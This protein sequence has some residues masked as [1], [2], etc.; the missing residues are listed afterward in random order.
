MSKR[1]YYDVLGVAKGAD[2]KD[3]KKAYRSL[4]N[5]YHPDKN[6][7]NEEALDKFKE[8]AEAYEILSSEEKRE[9]YDRFGH[10]G[11]NGQGGGYGG[12]AGAGGFSDIFG[13]VFGV[14]EIFEVYRR[15]K[16]LSNCLTLRYCSLGIFYRS[17]LS[18]YERHR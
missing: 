8:V 17:Y 1:D 5:K 18:W 3:I 14:C 9:A 15:H 11:V 2:K 16:N 6:P 4:A 10:E 7:D 12:G 13:D